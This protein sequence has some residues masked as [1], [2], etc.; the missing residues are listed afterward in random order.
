MGY[1]LGFWVKVGNS[2]NVG[3]FE[4]ILF[5]DTNDYGAINC[6]NPIKTS[7]NWFVWHI[8]D[9]YS[10]KV[11]KLTGDFRKS[12]IGI[13]FNPKSIVH[14]IKTGLYDGFYPDFE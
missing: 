6:D 12:E 2:S 9:V 5:R 7:N 4:H 3:T 8:N 10:T 13:V 11:G 1:K 14:R